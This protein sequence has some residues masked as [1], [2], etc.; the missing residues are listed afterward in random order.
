MIHA[1]IIVLMLVLGGPAMAEYGSDHSK[2]ERLL[3]QQ[4]EEQKRLGRIREMERTIE[5]IRRDGDR[6]L[7]EQDRFFRS[8]RSFDPKSGQYPR[9]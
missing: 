7:E 1:G 8:F 6:R 3:R 2:I 4:N 9:K 5:N